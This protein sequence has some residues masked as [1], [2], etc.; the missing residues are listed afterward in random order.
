MDIND[1]ERRVRLIEERN[2][3][4]EAEKAWEVSVFRKATIAIMTYIIASIVLVSIGSWQPF[5]SAL[6]PTIGYVLSVQSLPMI[7]RW[8]IRR[9]H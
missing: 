9:Q 1:I 3:R 6:I 7:R 8:W 4:V 5:L 2:V